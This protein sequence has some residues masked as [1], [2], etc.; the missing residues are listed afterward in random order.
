MK[1]KDVRKDS[2][3]R[4]TIRIN[5]KITPSTAKWMK[6]NNISPQGMF[7]IALQELKNG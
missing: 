5:L 4:K 6:K 1:L 3:E 7:D 2:K